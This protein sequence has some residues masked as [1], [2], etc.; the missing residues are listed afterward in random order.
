MTETV[1]EVSAISE[2]DTKESS[3]GARVANGPGIALARQDI[4]DDVGGMDA[5]GK[6]LRAG[7]LNRAE[8]VGQHCRQNLHPL[9]VAI[10]GALQLA[11]YAPPA[12][13]A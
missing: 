9:A 13:A 7:R 4:E 5:A 6:R 3:S 2:V 8:A 10:V 11:P 1:T 12:A